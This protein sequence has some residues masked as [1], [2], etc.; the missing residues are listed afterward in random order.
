MAGIGCTPQNGNDLWRLS[1][2]PDVAAGVTVSILQGR[3]G[4]C[5]YIQVGVVDGPSSAL[6]ER[7]N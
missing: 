4:T 5:M 6:I 1:R 7:A 2:Y 3:A